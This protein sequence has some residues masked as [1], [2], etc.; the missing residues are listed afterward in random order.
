MIINKLPHIKMKTINKLFVIIAILSIG[1]SEKEIL[2][3]N[4]N[5]QNGIAYDV[6]SRV[7]NGTCHYII[8]NG[9]LWKTTTYKRGKLHKEIA[10]YL[11]NG[12]IEYIGYRDK[13]GNI[14]GRFER[15][16]RNGK[17]E[18]EGQLRAGY[19]YGKWQIYNDKGDLVE[20]IEYDNNGNPINKN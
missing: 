11:D 6:N 20:E 17:I 5:T 10:Y 15:Y 18:L 16:F 12:G 3:C 2:P 4:L 7:Y 1:C 19:R 14:D 13:D 9:V 8:E